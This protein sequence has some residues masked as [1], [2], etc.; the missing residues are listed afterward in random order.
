MIA[1]N[2]QGFSNNINDFIL[3]VV[4]ILLKIYLDFIKIKL[5]D[6]TIKKSL[7]KPIVN[8]KHPA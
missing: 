5:L 7:S 6:L 3:H 1:I 2:N 8:S 4:I